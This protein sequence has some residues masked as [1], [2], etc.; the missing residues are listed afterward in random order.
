MTEKIRAKPKEPKPDPKDK[1]QV[2]FTIDR[3]GVWGGL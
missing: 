1:N 3:A 2:N